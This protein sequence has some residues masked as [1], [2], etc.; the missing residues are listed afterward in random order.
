MYKGYKVTKRLQ[1]YIGFAKNKFEK[2][3]QEGNAI[4]L[5]DVLLSYELIK[6]QTKCMQHYIY[7]LIVG[8]R[9]Y[10][11]SYKVLCGKDGGLY[12]RKIL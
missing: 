3:N 1:D 10:E 7:D 2:L 5:W 11:D 8:E 9:K 12:I 6:K 4:D